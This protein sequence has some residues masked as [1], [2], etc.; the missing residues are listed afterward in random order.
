[1]IFGAKPAI[2]R[3]VHSNMH[4]GQAIKG[5]REANAPAPILSAGRPRTPRKEPYRLPVADSS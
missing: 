5:P 2:M 4:G 3:C 1:M